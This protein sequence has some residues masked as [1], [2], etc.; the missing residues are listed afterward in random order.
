MVK[1]YIVVEKVLVGNV[2]YP[3]FYNC[4]LVDDDFYVIDDLEQY[5]VNGSGI[6]NKKVQ[7]S[8]FTVDD[9]GRHNTIL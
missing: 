5:L 3:C 6:S 4:A 8:Y 2:E 1:Y 9:N 7:G